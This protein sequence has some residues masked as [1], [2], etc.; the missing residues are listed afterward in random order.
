M[1]YK[2]GNCMVEF[3]SKKALV[4][5]MQLVHGCDFKE[6]DPEMVQMGKDNKADPDFAKVEKFYR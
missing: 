3:Q 5:H 2:C 6:G 1:G 4:S